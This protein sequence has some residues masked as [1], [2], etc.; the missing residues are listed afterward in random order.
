MVIRIES[1]QSIPSCVHCGIVVVAISLRKLPTG[2]RSKS[3]FAAYV[4]TDNVAEVQNDSV[5]D[6]FAGAPE[7]VFTIHII[8]T[9]AF[10]SAERKRA[11]RIRCGS[12]FNDLLRRNRENLITAVFEIEAIL[13]LRFNLD[14]YVV[15]ADLTRF[16]GNLGDCVIKGGIRRHDRGIGDLERALRNVRRPSIALRFAGIRHGSADQD[17]QLSGFDMKL[18]DA[19]LLAA[20]IIGQIA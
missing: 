18:I 6:L 11:V 20:I 8:G 19:R 14:G 15:G 12:R 3:E 4:I 10:L 2:S 16:A 9:E 1:I 13:I 7:V 17:F 5:V